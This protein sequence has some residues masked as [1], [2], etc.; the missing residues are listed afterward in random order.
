MIFLVLAIATCKD[1]GVVY[2]SFFSFPKCGKN[3]ITLVLPMVS[4]IFGI[5]FRTVVSLVLEI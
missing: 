3:V 5:Y 2:L 1:R 4:P